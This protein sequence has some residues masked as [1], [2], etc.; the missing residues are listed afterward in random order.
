[1]VIGPSLVRWAF[2]PSDHASNAFDESARN[3]KRTRTNIKTERTDLKVDQTALEAIE[4]KLGPMP[5]IGPTPV[6]SDR[7]VNIEEGIKILVTIW[8]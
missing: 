2:R 4:P 5:N 1:M 6:P 7:E 8:T 3:L